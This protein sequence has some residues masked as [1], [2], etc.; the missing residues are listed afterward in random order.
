MLVVLTNIDNVNYLNLIQVIYGDN[1]IFNGIPFEK[2]SYLKQFYTDPN[3]GIPN[4]SG[5]YYWVYWPDFDKQKITV[6][7]LEQKLVEYSIKNLQFPE[8]LKGKYKFIAEIK[9]QKFDK[10]Q[11][12]N[13]IFGLSESKKNDLLNY[14]STR[15]NIVT[16]YDFFKE[17]CFARPFYIGKANNLRTRL[18]NHFKGNSV[19]LP[20]LLKQR[21]N[22]SDIWIGYKKIPLEDTKPM[23]TIFEEILSRT[24]KP[25]LTK[26]PN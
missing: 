16:F 12:I 26:K 2:L 9:E 10:K 14:F 4:D 3:N 11:D 15:N 5:V 6:P 8:I 20:E 22:E 13:P 17:I 7:S 1:M 24:V 18:N 23:N 25:G 21:I 19:I